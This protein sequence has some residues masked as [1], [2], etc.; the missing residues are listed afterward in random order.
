MYNIDHR[1]KEFNAGMHYFLGVAEA[2]KQD[3]FM[4]CPCAVCMNLKEYLCSRTLHTHLLKSGFIP[5]YICWTK[6]GE[7]RVLM[8]DG[9]EDEEELDHADIIA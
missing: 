6:H 7:R 3:G 9:E 4:C 1:S 2:N 8:D 5:N